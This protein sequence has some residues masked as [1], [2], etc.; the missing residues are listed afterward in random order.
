MIKL[1]SKLNFKVH[2]PR[3][4]R[5]SNQLAAIA[6]VMLFASTQ[7]GVPQSN[8]NSVAHSSEM[9][10]SFVAA[11]DTDTARDSWGETDSESGDANGS[12]STPGILTTSK[13]SGKAQGLKLNLFR[14]RR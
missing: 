10:A 5:I 2:S 12:S 9:Q 1:N 7:V 11:T 6:A 8:E 3:R 13:K 4:R 14:F